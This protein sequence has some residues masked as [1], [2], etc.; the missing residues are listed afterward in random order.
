MPRFTCIEASFVL[1]FSELSES[2]REL[3]HHYLIIKRNNLRLQAAMQ[4]MQ[5]TFPQDHQVND[6][7]VQ[8]LPKNAIHVVRYTMRDASSAMEMMQTG[9]HTRGNAVK[10]VVARLVE[11]LSGRGPA[12]SRSG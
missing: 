11:R 6:A 3:E 5:A 2:M 8:A 9:M 12:W 10:R 4:Q 7:R 1:C